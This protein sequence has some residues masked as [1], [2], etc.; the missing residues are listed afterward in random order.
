M[1]D[2]KLQNP[3]RDKQISLVEA[4]RLLCYVKYQSEDTGREAHTGGSKTLT[5]DGHDHSSQDVLVL[6]QAARPTPQ[7]VVA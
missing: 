2:T 1:E 5:G 4:V 7:H 6:R 3:L